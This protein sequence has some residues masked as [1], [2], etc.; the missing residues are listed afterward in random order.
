[1]SDGEVSQTW[2]G[3][4]KQT[5]NARETWELGLFTILGQAL[6]SLFHIESN[7]HPGSAVAL[8]PWT[9]SALAL[10]PGELPVCYLVI[11]EDPSVG[12]DPQEQLFEIQVSTVSAG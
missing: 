4:A 10:D 7:S 9:L 2:V 3:E 1:M 5:S 11:P 8:R 6:L 12:V